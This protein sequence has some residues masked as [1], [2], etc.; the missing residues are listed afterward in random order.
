MPPPC[1]ASR[2]GRRGSARA[3]RSGQA[4]R[5]RG[6]YGSRD[7]A[8]PARRD[9]A[10]RRRARGSSSLRSPA[11]RSRRGETAPD[12]RRRSR[13]LR[14]QALRSR[15]LFRA[16]QPTATWPRPIAAAVRSISRSCS[17][18]S[19]GSAVRSTG[20]NSRTACLGA[21]APR[22]A[23]R[24]HPDRGRQSVRRCMPRLVIGCRK[25]RYFARPAIERR[26]Q[27]PLKWRRTK[28]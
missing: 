22:P 15:R 27:A 2:R 24:R 4:F 17:M 7:C 1:R 14:P 16:R 12:R 25:T 10:R 23:H 21:Q 13:S 28:T 9:A 19:S 8:S 3:R 20:R 11:P 18:I 6:S 26:L 5:N